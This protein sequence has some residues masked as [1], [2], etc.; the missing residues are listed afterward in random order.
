MAFMSP[1]MQQAASQTANPARVSPF[2]GM[3]PAQMSA[4]AA[5]N[6]N[7]DAAFNITGPSTPANMNGLYSA[8][9]QQGG[10]P[11]T[12]YMQPQG[13]AAPTM[14]WQMGM[15]QNQPVA[16]QQTWQP[17]Q[18]YQGMP[19]GGQYPT[20]PQYPNAPQQGPTGQPQTP[21]YGL[22]G[23]NAAL[24]G[25][26]GGG[27]QQR[28]DYSQINANRNMAMQQGNQGIASVQ[29]Y[30]QQGQQA[31]QQQAALSGALG[32]QAQQQAYSNF[33]SSPGQQWLQDQAL[34]GVTRN[35]AAIGGL[36][37][38]NVMQALQ[39]QAMGMAQQDYQ[40]QFNNLG[41]VGDRGMQAAQLQNALYQSNANAATSAGAQGAGIQ[42]SVIGANAG[43]DAAQIGANTALARDRGQYAF[44]AGQDIGNN[45]NATTSA[46][47][48]LANQQGSGM[49]DQYNAYIGNIANL[50][51][52]AGGQQATS[53]QNLASLL[54]NLA[55]GS[56][57]P[58]VGGSQVP[59]V[60]ASNGMGGLGNIMGG[61]G[62]I[63]Q[64]FGLGG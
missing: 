49:A 57:N 10:A 7:N 36:G 45:Y 12:N 60:G 31:N 58:F 26:M 59:G 30:N 35:A 42:G 5:A 19:A 2:A 6:P 61:I 17:Q 14:G 16:G 24:A 62:A 48:A 41:A 54:A 50:L 44:Q 3:T 53:D 46:L 15:P 32:Q 63:G 38:G 9:N 43:R 55:T 21:A 25:T 40:N 37:G 39:R 29:G 27:S 22:A 34:R 1:Y 18:P 8:F 13:G 23:A 51:A 47:A 33:A 64:G 4:A 11:L 20:Q 56:M 52:G 28:A